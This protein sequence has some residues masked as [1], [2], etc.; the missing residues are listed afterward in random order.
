MKR[1]PVSETVRQAAAALPAAF[2]WRNVAGV[3]YVSPVRNQGACE[4]MCTE[5]ES[6]SAL[7]STRVLPAS[8]ALP[9]APVVCYFACSV[10]LF[11]CWFTRSPRATGG[12][13]SCYAFSSAGM[14]EARF[15]VAS[16]NTQTPVL[17]PQ[18]I[19]ECCN[20]SQG[21]E[22]GFPYLVAG[23]CTFVCDYHIFYK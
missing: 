4:C 5:L 14:L 1:P 10:L 8:G 16:N 20:Y 11:T 12:C 21:C 17:S 19:V 9:R 2:D 23:V 3:S 15:R 7:Y 22:G 18:D 6:A 13:G